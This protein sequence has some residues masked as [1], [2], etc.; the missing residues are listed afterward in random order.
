MK[1]ITWNRDN[2]LAQFEGMTFVITCNVRNELNGLRKLHLK[3]EVVNTVVNG[4]WGPPYMPRRFPKGEWKITGIEPAKE[5]DFFPLKIKTNAH[6]MVET[7]NLDAQG[8]YDKP[9]GKQVDDSGYHLHWSEG[10]QT[11][12]GCGRVESAKQAVILA[13]LIWQAFDRKEEVV[14]KVV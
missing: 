4:Q 10:S 5:K 8:G 7:W 9:T 13:A 1:V 12:L 11:T 14:I 6:Q 2:G 3:S